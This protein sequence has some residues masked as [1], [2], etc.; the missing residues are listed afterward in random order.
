MQ[1]YKIVSVQSQLVSFIQKQRN[2]GSP[3]WFIVWKYVLLLNVNSAKK[4]ENIINTGYWVLSENRKNSFQSVLIAK[5][6][7]RETQKIANPQK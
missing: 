1:Y 4:N 7:S 6:S 2:A 3:G 5:I